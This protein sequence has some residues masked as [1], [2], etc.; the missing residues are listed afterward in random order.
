MPKIREIIDV[1]RER[2]KLLDLTQEDLAQISGVSLR[3]LK[4]IESGKG[5]QS[6]ETIIK[7][8]DTIGMTLRAEIKS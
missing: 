3:T 5:N 7:V 8:L 1:I 4:A 6:L 2:R